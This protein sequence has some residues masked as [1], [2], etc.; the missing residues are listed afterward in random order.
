MDGVRL[1]DEGE[2]ILIRCLGALQF[3]TILPLRRS[4]CAP[5]EAAAWFPLIGALV[6]LAAAGVQH[7]LPGPWNALGAVL[8]MVLLTRRSRSTTSFFP[9]HRC[10]T[11]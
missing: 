9:H 2:V 10:N 5:G 1:S 7:F 4:T 8:L 11:S 6:G 3:L